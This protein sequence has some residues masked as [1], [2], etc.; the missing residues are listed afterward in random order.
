VSIAAEKSAVGF[1]VYG[2]AIMQA[3]T[4]AVTQAL[5]LYVSF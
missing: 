4:F 3:R 5:L 1:A 2:S